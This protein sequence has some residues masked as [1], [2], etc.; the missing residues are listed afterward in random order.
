MRV[1]RIRNG[2]RA[3]EARRPFSQLHHQHTGPLGA[4]SAARYF[5][6]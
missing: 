3:E 2:R 5:S 6:P 1:E 4:V